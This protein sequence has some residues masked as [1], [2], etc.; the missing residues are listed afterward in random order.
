M[1]LW[2]HF[3]YQEVCIHIEPQYVANSQFKEK[4]ACLLNS[5]VCVC[6]SVHWFLKNTWIKTLILTVEPYCS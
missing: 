1:H 4:N 2:T 5:T 3:L 6:V